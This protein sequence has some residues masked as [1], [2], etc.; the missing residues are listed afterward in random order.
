RTCG[1]AGG[2][3]CRSPTRPRRRPLPPDAGPAVMSVDK[4]PAAPDIRLSESKR[5]LLEKYLRG[6]APG[7]PRAAEPIPRRAADEP[8]PISACQR[9]I[10]LHSELNPG[11][12]LYNEPLTIRRTGPLD[13]RALEWSLGEFL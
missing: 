1:W 12:P 13:V 5:R 11:L 6:D 10:W 8:A 7:R 9:P 2:R 3:L 4:S